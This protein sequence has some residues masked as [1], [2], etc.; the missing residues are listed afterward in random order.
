MLILAAVL[1]ARPA[2]HLLETLSEDTTYPAQAPAGTINDASRLNQTEIAEVWEVPVL[3]DN[4]EGQLADL[5]LRARAEGL[6]RAVFRGSAE[7]GYGK[8]LRWNLETRIQPLLFEKIFSRNQ[9]LNEG[10]EVFENRSSHS[11]DILHEYFVPRPR[12]MEFVD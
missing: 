5:L 4:F 9:L 1:L 2:F 8:E 10:V 6:R 12:V 7:S 11:T 3:S